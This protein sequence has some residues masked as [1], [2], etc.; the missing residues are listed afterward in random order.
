M[1]NP[2]I[3]RSL[4][5]RCPSRTEALDALREAKELAESANRAKSDFLAHMSHEIRTPMNGILGITELLQQTELS[6]KQHHFVDIVYRS[7]ATLLRL[8]NDVLDFSKIEAGKIEL[9]CIRLDLVKTVRE[10]TDLFSEQVQGKGIKLTCVLAES[11]PSVL[12]G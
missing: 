12:P 2:T 1:R 6:G 9:E 8:I 10:V 3:G 11:V 5:V 7:G 4:S